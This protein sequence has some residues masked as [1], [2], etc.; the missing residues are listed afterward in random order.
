MKKISALLLILFSG[1]IY[2]GSNNAR[3]TEWF[4]EYRTDHT[5]FIVAHRGLGDLYNMCPLKEFNN[6]LIYKINKVKSDT[7]E[8]QLY[9]FCDSYL[10]S[11]VEKEHFYGVDSLVK[12][13]WWDN[14]SY[15]KI[16][17]LRNDKKNVLIIELSERSVRDACHDFKTMIA[18]L[19]FDLITNTSTQISSK[20]LTEEFKFFNENINSNLELNIFS[21]KFFNRVRE[22]KAGLNYSLFNRLNP[23]VYLDSEKHFLF[24]SPTLQGNSNSNSF[25]YMSKEEFENISSV[26]QKTKEHFFVNGFDEVYFSFIPNPVSVVHPKLG[27]YNQL[28]PLLSSLDSSIIKTIDVYSIFKRNPK[29]YYAN[30]DTHWNSSGLQ[31][32]L[33]ET[34]QQLINFLSSK[35]SK[36]ISRK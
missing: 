25:F 34:N 9:L 10:V 31:K 13:K 22:M 21:Y 7:K 17:G 35:N 20:K 30:N 6:P 24:Y 27:E 12:I 36:S 8:I 32:W 19:S 16:D 26:L 11:H 2:F 3:F 23:N 18:P 1:I 15:Q 28:L 14:N 29:M 33:D 4:T 5:S